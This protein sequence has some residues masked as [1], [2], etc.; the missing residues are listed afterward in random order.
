MKDI[1]RIHIAK[2]P[3]NIEIDAKKE[4]QDYIHSL[5]SYSV[6]S[7]VLED[8]EIRM[9]EL[10]LERGVKQED[11][12]GKADIAAIR[13]QLGEPKDFAEEDIAAETEIAETAGRNLYRDIDGAVI[14]GVLAGIAKYLRINVIWVRLLFIT[15]S[16]FSFG[17]FVLLYIVA[18]MVIPPAR[19]AAEKLQLAG[20][21]VTLSSIRAL[22]ELGGTGGERRS[23]MVKR[24]LTLFAGFGF[25][26]AAL[27]SIALIVAVGFNMA[28]VYDQFSYADAMKVAFG[29]AFASGVLLTVLLLLAAFASFTQKITKKMIIAAVT[30]I[31]LGIATFTTFVGMTIYEQR[32]AYAQAERDRSETRIALPETMSNIDTVRIDAPDA[33]NIDYQAVT[34]SK[35]SAK[36]TGL[37][38][39]SIASI[40]VEGTTATITIKDMKRRS[41]G[42]VELLAISGPKLT[43]VV[44]ERGLFNYKTTDRQD[45]TVEA[46]GESVVALLDSEIA[47]LTADL[48]GGSS[49][50]TDSAAVS[51]VKAQL[52]DT[53]SIQLGTVS[54]LD[55]TAPDACGYDKKASLSL[56]GVSGDLFQLNGKESSIKSESRRSCFDLQLTDYDE[57]TE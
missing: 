40:T 4:L 11:V 16:L 32:Q 20:K 31:I 14:G 54:A 44:V 9:T 37:K 22:N 29:F 51:T 36:Q 1:T 49:L 56:R 19:T 35:F 52:K 3:Y 28:D 26:A 50:Q 38:G 48:S 17:I 30:I 5:E 45:L 13:G 34:G 23:A 25:V 2:V 47:T 27:G 15:A 57:Y 46:R 24:V 18:W 10:L 43:N 41:F 53:S 42:P 7:D 39:N 6:E 55:I 8:I 33:V 12:I 21:P